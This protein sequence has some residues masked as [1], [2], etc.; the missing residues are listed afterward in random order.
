MLEI[1]KNLVV[2]IVSVAIVIVNLLTLFCTLRSKTQRKELFTPL[3]VSIFTGDLIQGLFMVSFNSYISWKNITEP[4]LWLVRLLSVYI[5][6]IVVSVCIVSLLSFWQ[7]I[8]IIKPLTFTAFATKKKTW[9][10]VVVVWV[11]AVF[12]SLLRITSKEVYYDNTL[13]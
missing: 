1:A 5:M 7:T 6:G 11:W 9:I 10:G 2:T 8:A 12:V 4:P 3:T 13:R